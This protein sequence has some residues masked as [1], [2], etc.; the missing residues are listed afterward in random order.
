MTK[1]IVII[2]LCV[3]IVLISA[4]TNISKPKL[5]VVKASIINIT[6]E[7]PD[8]ITEC[9]GVAIDNDGNILTTAHIIKEE[10]DLDNI[11]IYCNIKSV[12]YEAHIIAIDRQKDLALIKC[13]CLINSLIT[14]IDKDLYVGEKIRVA[15]NTLNGGNDVEGVV[16]NSNQKI[17]YTT[18]T[19]DLLS[20][21][22]NLSLGYSGSPVIDNKG[23]AVGIIS[24]K[25]VNDNTTFF[26]IKSAEIIEFLEER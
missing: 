24:A 7:Y 25:K 10:Y 4:C 14:F 17:S 19:R 12:K 21:N 8:I 18:Y 11:S 5:A 20:I 13:G 15:V 2:L 9:V 23:Y 3:A 26:A 16:I 22:A 1:K 6:L